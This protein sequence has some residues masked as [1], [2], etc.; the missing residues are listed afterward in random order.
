MRDVESADR[1]DAVAAMLSDEFENLFAE[2]GVGDH[3]AAHVKR[4]FVLHD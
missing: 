2:N 3:Q 4:V 1:C